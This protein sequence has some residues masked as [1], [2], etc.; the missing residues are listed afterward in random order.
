[1]VGKTN[2]PELGWKADTDN[3]TFGPTCNPWSLAHSPGGSSGGS[4]AAIASGMVPLATGSDGGCDVVVV[5]AHGGGGRG[6]GGVDGGAPGGLS[7]GRRFPGGGA[8]AGFGGGRGERAEVL[9]QADHQCA[10]RPAELERRA[11]DVGEADGRGER[12]R[13]GPQERVLGLAAV[14]A[15]AGYV[16]VLLHRLV[17]E[18]RARGVGAEHGV[19]GA[20]V[21]R[22]RVMTV[23]FLRPRFGVMKPLAALQR[24][25]FFCVN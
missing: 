6:A 11:G 23:R 16:E 24:S 17:G 4:A 1:M 8:F 14:E 25:P 2:T 5:G 19:L 3:T 21:V 22:A 12:L 10:Q 7:G 9:L 13:E 18:Q 15:G 20:R